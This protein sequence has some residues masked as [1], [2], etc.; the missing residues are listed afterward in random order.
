MLVVTTTED[1]L[2]DKAYWDAAF[3]IQCCSLWPV[4]ISKVLLPQVLEWQVGS[5][6]NLTYSSK[7]SVYA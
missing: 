7:Y 5:L 2:V 6:S 3:Q 4:Q 1:I